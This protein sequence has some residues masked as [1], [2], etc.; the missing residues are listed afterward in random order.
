[1]RAARDFVAAALATQAVDGDIDTILLLVS[2]LATNAVRHAA[3][4]FDVTVEVRGEG[5]RVAVIDQDVA[6]PPRLRRPELHSTDGRGLMIV[7]ELASR[8]GTDALGD[9]T[10]AVWFAVD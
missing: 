3:T 8:W 7:A 6:H 10:K 2:E 9:G 4:P 5:V 1:M